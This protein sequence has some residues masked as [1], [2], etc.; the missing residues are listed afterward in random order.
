MVWFLGSFECACMSGY[1]REG[2]MCINIDECSRDI[3]DCPKPQNGQVVSTDIK[4]SI[5]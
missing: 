3:A 1:E 5:F 2:T 4:L